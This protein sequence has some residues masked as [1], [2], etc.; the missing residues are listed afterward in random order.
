MVTSV[1]FGLCL[2]ICLLAT[3]LW[4]WRFG[5]LGQLVIVALMPLMLAAIFFSYTRSV[6]MG[7]GLGVLIVLGLTLR[8][9]WRPLVVGGIVAAALLLVTTRMD[10]LMGFQRESSA[11]ETKYSVDMRQSFAYASWQMFLDR[12]L[13]GVGFGQFPDAKLPYLSDRSVGLN[14]EAI[15]PHIHHNTFLSLLTE[16]GLIGLGLFL[17]ILA[18]WARAAWGL[19][20]NR[21]APDWARAQGVLLLG[22]LA[23]YVCQAAFH[24]LSYGP[25]DNSVVFLLAGMTMGLQPSAAPVTARIRTRFDGARLGRPPRPVSART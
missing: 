18:G 2:G 9:S 19:C 24:E 10:D 4:R 1:S 16:T 7:V 22:V 15:R 3:W 6:W 14:L 17:A 12:P 23:I 5:R 25:L 13:W 20:H 11:A 8:G 21:E